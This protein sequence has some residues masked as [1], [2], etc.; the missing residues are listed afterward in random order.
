[1][2]NGFI[3]QEILYNDYDKYC[4]NAAKECVCQ[5]QFTKLI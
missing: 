1:M 4:I 2:Y 5:K 3:F